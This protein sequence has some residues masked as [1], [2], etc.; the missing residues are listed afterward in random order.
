VIAAAAAVI[1]VWSYLQQP[2]LRWRHIE[3]TEHMTES[4]DRGQYT[5]L[6]ANKGLRDAFNVT[7]VASLEY[8]QL[9]S[10]NFNLG[11]S[12]TQSVVLGQ[13]DI[14]I[15]LSRIPKGSAS[16]IYVFASSQDSLPRE[17]EVIKLIGDEVQG[18][19]WA[20]VTRVWKAVYSGVVLLLLLLCIINIRRLRFPKVRSGG[21]ESSMTDIVTQDALDEIK[22]IGAFELKADTEDSSYEWKT[23]HLAGLEW[24]QNRIKNAKK[25]ISI[26]SY[27]F[28]S[29]ETQLEQALEEYLQK[30]ST[31][32]LRILLLQPHSPSFVQKTL[33]ESFD[34]Q[35]ELFTPSQWN[36]AA[37]ELR[38]LHA[39]DLTQTFSIVKRWSNK[40]G[41]ERVKCRTYF[42]TPLFAGFLFDDD[43]F[44]LSSYFLDPVMRG[45]HSRRL[46][47][48]SCGNSDDLQ[49]LRKIFQNWFTVKFAMGGE[50][51]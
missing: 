18:E 45:F 11:L 31:C 51:G 5:L 12:D 16:E 23:E 15:G 28:V 6:I 38:K 8:G 46:C 49:V 17:L 9:D 32:R 2:E 7:F 22:T 37:M 29:L 35:A 27:S 1:G 33:L 48:E 50:A 30:D 39:H 47:V 13:T 42:D 10:A 26:V 14:E 21:Y 19:E 4:G 24:L 3:T 41:A 20:P 34:R 40:Y 44:C 43:A 36:K 25:Q